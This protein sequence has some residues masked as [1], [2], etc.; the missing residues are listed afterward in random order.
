VSIL[1]ISRADKHTSI[2]VLR[3]SLYTGLQVRIARK[4]GVNRSFVCRVM[5]GEKKSKRVAVALE[6]EFSRIEKQIE[7]TL[8]RAA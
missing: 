3:H 2:G 6:R 4:L 5:N 8:A 7:R 1:N